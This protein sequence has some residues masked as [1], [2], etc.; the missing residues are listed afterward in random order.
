[1]HEVGLDN[2]YSKVGYIWSG[3][4]IEIEHYTSLNMGDGVTL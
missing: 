3:V 1:M 4:Y 2:V